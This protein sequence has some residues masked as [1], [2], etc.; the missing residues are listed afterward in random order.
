MKKRS[1]GTLEATNAEGVRIKAP[2][3]RRMWRG[4]G[5]ICVGT[6]GNAVPVLIFRWER[7]SQTYSYFPVGTQFLQRSVTISIRPILVAQQ[8]TILPLMN[9][10]IC[11]PCCVSSWAQSLR[12]IVIVI[13]TMTIWRNDGPSLIRSTALRQRAN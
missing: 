11:E 9:V 8:T 10:L 6:V 1:G 5:L 4:Q 12:Q 2:R 7:R 3:G 13:I